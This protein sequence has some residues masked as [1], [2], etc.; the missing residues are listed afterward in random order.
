M[1]QFRCLPGVVSNK[2]LKTYFCL[3]TMAEVE[4]I[5]PS[6]L[7]K[8]CTEEFTYSP[9]ILSYSP[10]INCIVFCH[11]KSSIGYFH[12]NSRTLVHERHQ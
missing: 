3:V 11:K 4:T 6:Y 12:V 9:I 1:F 2:K 5:Q 8:A 7:L 10:S